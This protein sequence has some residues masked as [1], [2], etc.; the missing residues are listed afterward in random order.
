MR[1]DGRICLSD[2]SNAQE[3]AKRLDLFGGFRIDVESKSGG[4]T[5]IYAR[6]RTFIEAFKDYFNIY[7]ASRA[8]QTVVLIKTVDSILETEKLDVMKRAQA[9][10]NIKAVAVEK[11]EFKGHAI[12]AR[13][14]D[15][16]KTDTEIL[17]KSK[18]NKIK[19]V[20]NVGLVAAPSN[21]KVNLIGVSPTLVVAGRAYLRKITNEGP[22][23]DLP[24]FNDTKI[25]RS[26]VSEI[27]DPQPNKMNLT[28][29]KTEADI[30]KHFFDA[31]H[32]VKGT[33]VLEPLPDKVTLNEDGT[34]KYE[35]TDDGLKTMLS[36][37][38]KALIP[39]GSQKEIEVSVT[40]ATE[41]EKLIRR[42]ENL[43]EKM[44]FDII[45]SEITF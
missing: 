27:M 42:I 11:K 21:K 32:R 40:I 14:L 22:S 8:A 10:V 15:D 45:S 12:A 44:K 6:K 18:K 3:L 25:Q 26:Q 33:V 35:Y 38:K 5:E 13:I 36:A 34:L 16:L 23:P 20:E 37:I 28:V 7:S 30:G 29:S 1:P 9:L 4:T 17:D 24:A 41:D 39:D 2:A 43:S 31:L 19:V